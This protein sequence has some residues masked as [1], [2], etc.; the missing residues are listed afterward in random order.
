MQN[1]QAPFVDSETL[2][3]KK[4]FFKF[5][6]LCAY[7]SGVLMPNLILLKLS[8]QINGQT[9]RVVIGTACLGESFLAPYGIASGTRSPGST[10]PKLI[11]KLLTYPETR[12][13]KK[14]R[15]RS[16]RHSSYEFT[17]RQSFDSQSEAL[18]DSAN[19]RALS[20]AASAVRL[21]NILDAF[22]GLHVLDLYGTV[23]HSTAQ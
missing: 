9:S 12:S 21:M 5:S 3:R 15:I 2:T 16:S 22:L 23:Q 10:S 18:T 11:H 8:L 6:G 7:V 13:S 20:A 17:I 1:A 4:P 19:P 14:K